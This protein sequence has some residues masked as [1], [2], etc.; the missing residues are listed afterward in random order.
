MRVRKAFTLMEILVVVL[1][2]GIL[3]AIVLP[4]FSNVS[5]LARVKMMA[6]DLRVI[7][8]QLTLYKCQHLEI[9]AG[10]P[11]G[12]PSQPPTEAAFVLH[13]SKASN[14]D[15]ETAELGTPG[16]RFGPYLREIPTNPVNG[17]NSVQVVLDNEVFPAAGDDSHGWVYQPSR[18]LFKADSPGAD[19]DGK[20]LFSY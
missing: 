9:G 1:I 14:Q 5:G 3:A 10:Y 16:F 19:E 4:Q 18:L 17:K 12:D 2:L 7:R 8:T 13:M 20:L 11:D 15:G 6:D